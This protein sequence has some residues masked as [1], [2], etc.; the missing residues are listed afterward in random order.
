MI[1]DSVSYQLST[2]NYFQIESIKKQ[3]V[4][5][6]TYNHDMKHIIGWQHRYNGKYKKTAAYTISADG[7]V[8]NHFQPKFQ[9]KY[10]NNLEMDKKSVVILLENDGWLIKDDKTNEFFTWIGDIYNEPSKIVEK[11]WRGYEYW[12]PYNKKQIKSLE[13]LVKLLCDEFSIPLIAIDHNTKL[14]DVLDYEG[15]IYRS[16]LNKNYT[17]LSPSWDF[18]MFKNKIEIK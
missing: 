15:I 5:G 8:Y 3:I 14:D 12:A 10:F 11:K 6:H 16:N 7:V 13:G 17:D 18:I 9:S 1:I 2:D 4:I